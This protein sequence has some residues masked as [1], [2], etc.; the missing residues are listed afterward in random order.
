[1][2]KFIF[3]SLLAI[4]MTGCS[5]ESMDSEEL[6]TA[7][8]K[9]KV[10]EVDKSMNLE[11]VEICAGEAP[12]FVFNFPQDA[13]GKGNPKDTNIKIQIETSP[14]SGVWES[15]KDL[16]YAGAGPEEY[17]YENEVLEIGTYSF[18]VS[19]GSGGF[20]YTATLDIIECSDCEESFSYT[21]NED[22]S[23]TFTYIPEE[24]MEDAEVVFTFAQSVVA[25]GYH[26]PDW[27][28]KSSTRTETMNLDACSEYTWTISLT[29]DCSGNSEESNLW[30]DFK[31]DEVSK[32][33]ELVNITRS[34]P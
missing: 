9:F 19:I 31:V 25:S 17:T 24:D 4:G 26:W 30:T 27:N 21:T 18:R 13:L 1:M 32:K 8:A 15:F 7:D 5:V 34:C 12:V 20:L 16:T 22:G 33:G 23:Y 29:G 10:Q 3:L 14:G 6:L 2:K 28:G 11:A